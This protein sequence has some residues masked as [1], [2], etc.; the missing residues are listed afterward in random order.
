MRAPGLHS[1]HGASETATHTHMP[2]CCRSQDRTAANCTGA[3]QQAHPRA[4]SGTHRWPHTRLV[5]IT[6]HHHP[7]T[8]THP[9]GT[10]PRLLPLASPHTRQRQVGRGL[11]EGRCTWL[12][13]GGWAA[14]PLRA[15]RG[16][17]PLNV[18]PPP[19]PAAPMKLKLKLPGTPAPGGP[20]GG[21]NPASAS[22]PHPPPPSG[23]GGGSSFTPGG[24]PGLLRFPST[25]SMA[26]PTPPPP[27]QGQAQGQKRKLEDGFTGG[28]PPGSAG[29]PL[30]KRPHSE[31][32]GV[33]PPQL[34]RSAPPG[35]QSQG[36]PGLQP[37]G[38]TPLPGRP[39]GLMRHPS[40][41]A[42]A[43]PGGA[44]PGLQAFR[45]PGSLP[46][47]R[48]TLT[49][50]T[51]P[52]GGAGR[53]PPL[54]PATAP[55]GGAGAGGGGGISDQARRIA[56]QL[57][58]Q[59]GASDGTPGPASTPHGAAPATS[60]QASPGSGSPAA[61][62][63]KMVL[64]GPG[65]P[66]QSGPDRPPPPPP[67][68][69]T[70]ASG[71]PP[72][73]PPGLQSF[74]FTIK[75]APPGLQSSVK[76]EP[77]SA[78][79]GGPPSGGGFGGGVGPAPLPTQLQR[80]PVPP[81]PQS[82][83]SPSAGG[84]MTTGG[85]EH[86]D[87]MRQPQHTHVHAQAAAAYG[88][89]AGG[90]GPV[91]HI[92]SGAPPHLQMQRSG[93]AGAPGQAHR[94]LNPQQQILRNIKSQAVHHAPRQIGQFGPRPQAQL[95]PMPAAAGPATPAPAFASGPAPPGFPP[96]M[97]S[98]PPP[99]PAPGA[100]TIA[101]GAPPGVQRL[102]LPFK[103]KHAPP[104]AP[105]PLGPIDRGG[106]GGGSDDDSDADHAGFKV[107]GGERCTLSP[108]TGG[109]GVLGASMRMHGR[110]LHPRAQILD[111]GNPKGEVADNLGHSLACAAWH[112][113][114]EKIRHARLAA[115]VQQPA[116]VT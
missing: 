97:P 102:K 80:P 58:Q 19:P 114:D 49:P 17:R 27:A 100:G 73:R 40:S 37:H 36:P 89:E 87:H 14:A 30:A 86:G 72:G 91:P 83:F 92:G 63:Q 18:R 2:A 82:A 15:C 66:G 13:G 44:P 65:G 43:T 98:Q 26:G 31:P 108:V 96:P 101:S 70:P 7:H 10:K 6:I 56:L 95:P 55:A 74:R 71:G 12:A 34:Q 9:L 79:G 107:R 21:P 47:S 11:Q 115:V 110:M 39:P 76:A 93:S 112:G 33:A 105:K 3:V 75:N 24:P 1:A 59:F 81:P 68:G 103:I 54:P 60:Q 78:G 116:R 22:R 62:K 57:S 88:A 51:A 94:P 38:V 84:L 8:V 99:P 28:G 46:P 104:V 20:S 85:G 5:S 52:A 41:A 29:L 113:S 32:S 42:A 69:A 16:A 45:P 90:H 67:L 77:G 35:L 53:P 25:A 61:K 50:H 64:S 48:P 106:D 4:A 111:G 109:L 23:G